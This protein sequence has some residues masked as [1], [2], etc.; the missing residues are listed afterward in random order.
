MLF[1]RGIRGKAPKTNGA[2]LRDWPFGLPGF[3]PS[4]SFVLYGL[5]PVQSTGKEMIRSHKTRS[6]KITREVGTVTASTLVWKKS[7]GIERLRKPVNGVTVAGAQDG[8]TL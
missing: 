1:C 8:P 2:T 6:R 4:Q 3:P 5:S 7:R